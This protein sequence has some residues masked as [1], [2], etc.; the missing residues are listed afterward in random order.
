MAGAGSSA[1]PRS[2]DAAPVSGRSAPVGPPGPRGGAGD[3]GVW[4]GATRAVLFAAAATVGKGFAG[5]RRELLSLRADIDRPGLDTLAGRKAARSRVLLI[6]GRPGWG[7][8]ALAEELARRLADDYPDG[9]LTARLTTSGGQPVPTLRTARDLLGRLGVTAPPGADEDDLS[10][11]LREKLTG[12]RLLLLLDDVAGVEQVDALLPDE[13]GCLVVAVSRGPLTGVPDVRPCTVGGLDVSA[14]VGL[15]AQYAGPTRITCDPVAAQTLVGECAG[16]PAALVLAG[17]WLAVQPEASVADLVARLRELPPSSAD[18]DPGVRPLARTFRLVYDSLPPAVARM[19]RLLVLAPAGSPDAHVASALAGCSVQDGEAA[20]EGFAGCGLLRPVAYGRYQVPGCLEPLLR[21]LLESVERPAEVELARA[22]MLERTVRQLHACRLAA[23]PVGSPARRELAEMP[24]PLR[25]SSSSAAA[26]WLEARLPVLLEAARLAVEAGELDTLARRLVA[27][28][29]H[30]LSA[31]RGAEG[32]A[33]ELYGLH[34]LVL[35]VAERRDLPVERAAALLNLGDLDA[36]ADRVDQ[37]LTRYKGALEAAREAGDAY[38]TGRALESIGG[39]H[40]ELGD[41]HRA[42]DWYGRALELR[43]SRRDVAGGARVYARLGTVHGYAGRWAEALRDWRAAAAACRRAD[44]LA[45]CARALSGTARAQEQ[46]GRTRDALRS[47]G[48]AV[49][50]ARG[51][52]DARLHG[53]LAL[54]AAEA[55]DRLGGDPA[56]ARV[57][58]QEAERA[59]A[60]EKGLSPEE[61]PPTAPPEAPRAMEED[62]I[63]LRNQ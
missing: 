42:A 1:A 58:R 25:F 29:T 53:E 27:G 24:R 60:P 63:D 17:G 13:P 12:K 47:W 3:G 8:T 10:E 37:A 20:L 23:E 55:V 46:I 21:E 38:T 61:S 51:C 54:R 30:A 33:P 48:E 26:G 40:Q 57:L 31:H 11:A 34:Q 62:E 41:W 44:D 7:R 19:L 32:A 43:L 18:A 59:E 2:A 28:L 14:A 35:D 5:R 9:V 52:G 36:R 22:R 50:V 4:G 16:Q 49:T 56:V 45:G 39:I 15:L 6:A